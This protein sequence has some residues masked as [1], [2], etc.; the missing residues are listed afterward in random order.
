[1]STL[2]SL[3]HVNIALFGK[4]GFA[5]IL[6]VKNFDKRSSWFTQWTINPMIS[7]LIREQTQTEE[8]EAM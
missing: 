3:K 7:V 6:E 5:D 1:M 8:E 2:K 4:R